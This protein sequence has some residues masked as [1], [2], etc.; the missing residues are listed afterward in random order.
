LGPA[1]TKKEFRIGL[2]ALGQHTHRS[3]RARGSFLINLF[4]SFVT[5]CFSLPRLV[6]PPRRNHTPRLDLW[7]DNDFISSFLFFSLAVASRRLRRS[8]MDPSQCNRGSY[9]FLL[10]VRPTPARSFADAKKGAGNTAPRPPTLGNVRLSNNGGEA[11]QKSQLPGMWVALQTAAVPM[12]LPHP[13][14]LGTAG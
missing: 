9:C 6:G 8:C 11:S 12:T 10:L 4:I 7:R 3:N 5:V 14:A 13:S 2:A 1:H